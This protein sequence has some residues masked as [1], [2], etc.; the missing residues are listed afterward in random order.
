MSLFDDLGSMIGILRSA[1][2]LHRIQ[3]N[4]VSCQSFSSQISSILG[5]QIPKGARGHIRSWALL[6]LTTFIGTHDH[7][8][9]LSLDWAEIMIMY[10]ASAFRPANVRAARQSRVG[11]SS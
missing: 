4:Y 6:N 9:S 2:S 7:V 10:I 1:L 3:N 11:S 8:Y 5:E